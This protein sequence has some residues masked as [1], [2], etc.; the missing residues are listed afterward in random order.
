MPSEKNQHAWSPAALI[1]QTVLE[2]WSINFINSLSKCTGKKV[3]LHNLASHHEGKCRS[4]C[5][6]P[7]TI[8]LS[9]KYDQM[10]TLA[11]VPPVTETPITHQTEGRVDPRDSRDALEKGRLL[12]IEP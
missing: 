6:T 5:E 12:G 8:N 2:S 10:H 4:Q 3:P 11:T 1:S 9:S 7:C